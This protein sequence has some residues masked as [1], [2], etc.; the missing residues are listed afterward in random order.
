[1]RRYV[2]ASGVE[3][4]GACH[5]FRHTMAT[6]MLEGGAD[7]RYVQEMLGHS[8]LETTQ[9]YTQVAI[10]KL[11]QIHSATHP[12]AGLKP[13]HPEDGEPRRALE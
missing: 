4:E 6:L 5:L 7:I 3:K 10:D 9:I 1:V 2:E 13:R 11:K 12:G 8:K